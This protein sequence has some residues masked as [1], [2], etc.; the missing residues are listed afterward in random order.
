M[1]TYR[2]TNRSSGA[3]LGTWEAETPAGALDALSRDAG[4]RDQAHACEVLESDGGDLEV[5][6]I[7]GSI[8]RYVLRNDLRNELDACAGI[9]QRFP[10]P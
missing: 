5:E 7:D 3:D 9:E 10:K 1:T 2:I 6:E 8:A 4:Y